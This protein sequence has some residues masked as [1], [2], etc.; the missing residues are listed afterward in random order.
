M[1]GVR[2]ESV[3]RHDGRQTS[4]PLSANNGLRDIRWRRSAHGVGIA[5][6][7]PAALR[8]RGVGDLHPAALPPH[9]AELCAL[10]NHTDDR[11]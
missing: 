10:C 2:F 7:D 8:R 4:G 5:G 6:L 9:D 11:R 1:I 3:S